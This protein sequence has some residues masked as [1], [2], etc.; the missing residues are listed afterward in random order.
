MEDY[1]YEDVH[2]KKTIFM[3]C[4]NF[5]WI[6]HRIFVDDMIH[7]NPSTCEELKRQFIKEYKGDF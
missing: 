4:K 6:I 3:R 2:S 5:E 7:H 1:G